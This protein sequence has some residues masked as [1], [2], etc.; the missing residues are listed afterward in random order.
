MFMQTQ[1]Q[2]RHTFKVCSFKFLK[3]LRDTFFFQG[4]I[5]YFRGTGSH[6]SGKLTMA[7][8]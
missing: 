5:F 2:I 6:T 1:K 4:I 3:N 8:I 7:Y